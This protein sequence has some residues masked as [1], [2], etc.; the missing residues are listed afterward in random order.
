MSNFAE[1]F[2]ANP[3][4][5]EGGEFLLRWRGRQEGPYPASVIESKLASNQIGLLHEIL[6]NGQWITIRD[7]LTERETT[8][9]AEQQAREDRERREREEAEQKARE[10]EEQLRAAVLVEER[11]RNDLLAAEMERQSNASRALAVPQT[12]LK[13]HR[14]GAIMALGLVGLFVCGPLCLAAWSM[15]SSDLR[16]MDSGIMDPSG[17]STTSTG[18][19]CGVLGTVLWGVGLVVLF[20]LKVAGGRSLF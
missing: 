19:D 11:R 7:Y 10:R 3:G 13:P 15:G 5:G 17:R 20:F 6:H 18:R 14:G 1:L 8:L 2:S 4:G 16:A 12:L 9:R